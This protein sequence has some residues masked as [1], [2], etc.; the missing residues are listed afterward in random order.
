LSHWKSIGYEPIVKHPPL[1]TPL[2]SMAT[3]GE[4]E[5]YMLVDAVI[6]EPVSEEEFPANRENYSEISSPQSHRPILIV[7][8]T[9]V[10]EAYIVFLVGQFAFQK[11]RELFLPEQGSL[12]G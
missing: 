1:I 11:N 9:C 4:F 5:S 3:T 6:F 7:P 2:F 10:F 8:R 12:S